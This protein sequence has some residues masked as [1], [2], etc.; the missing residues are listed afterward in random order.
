LHQRT[1]N[2]KNMLFLDDDPERHNRFMMMVGELGDHQVTQLFHAEAVTREHVEGKD[3]LFL[4]HDLCL[5]FYGKCPY[6]GGWYNSGGCKCPDGRLVVRRLIEW[7]DPSSV[8]IVVHSANPTRGNEM[9]KMLIEAGFVTL[10]YDFYDWWDDYEADWE[11]L[12]AA[13]ISET[14]FR[15]WAE[16]DEDDEDD[17]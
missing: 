4:D 2:V 6:L 3:I 15:S 1:H 11:G 5:N 13:L 12:W 17:E 16:D 7:L 14:G 9:A 10:R 8:R